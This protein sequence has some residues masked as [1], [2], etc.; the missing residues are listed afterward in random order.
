MTSE[1]IVEAYK[2]KK[3]RASTNRAV[4]AE[5]AAKSGKTVAQVRGILIFNHVYMSTPDHERFASDGTELTTTFS[6]DNYTE[7]WREYLSADPASPE[8]KKNTINDIA[9]RLK[10]T[11]YAVERVIGL[12]A[13]PRTAKEQEAEANE[14]AL[15]ELG[16]QEQRSAER[17]ATMR[18]MLAVALGIA[19]IVAVISVLSYR[20]NTTPTASA[21]VTVAEPGYSDSK[22]D[23][24]LVTAR[25]ITGMEPDAQR[26]YDGLSP[27][28]QEYVREKMK[29]YDEICATSDDC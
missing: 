1:E 29:K 28:G 4:V 11:P 14:Q 24:G 25:P 21:P 23:G 5:L 8:E 18:R 9:A 16:L 2:A 3:P 17:S 10:A 26:R 7:V 19:A 12:A 6:D 13:R 27:E 20:N 22:P 15:L